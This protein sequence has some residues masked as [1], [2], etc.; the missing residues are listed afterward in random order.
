M[1]TNDKILAGR[2]LIQKEQEMADKWYSIWRIN[3]VNLHIEYLD[4]LKA[5]FQ[6]LTGEKQKMEI[7]LNERYYE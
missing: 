5:M 1:I 6:I 7:P 2:K 3:D 4:G